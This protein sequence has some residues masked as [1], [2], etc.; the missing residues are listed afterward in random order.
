MANTFVAKGRAPTLLLTKQAIHNKFLTALRDMAKAAGGQIV[1]PDTAL[2]QVTVSS[3]FTAVVSHFKPALVSGA[4][5][6]RHPWTATTMVRLPSK[7]QGVGQRHVS[8]HLPA[9]P[10]QG[11]RGFALHPVTQSIYVG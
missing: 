6:T 9:M 3:R 1:D 4:R 8:G 7:F 10:R 2:T 5:T 11:T